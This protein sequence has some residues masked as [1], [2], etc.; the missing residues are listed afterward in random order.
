[1][2]IIYDGVRVEDVVAVTPNSTNPWEY[3]TSNYEDRYYVIKDT[4]HNSVSFTWKNVSVYYELG[5]NL[6]DY[7]IDTVVPGNDGNYYQI[8][9]LQYDGGASTF[10]SIREATMPVDVVEA[11]GAVVYD[12]AE[13]VVNGNFDIDTYGWDGGGTGID[14]LAEHSSRTGVGFLDGKTLNVG[15]W[16]RQVNIPVEIGVTYTFSCWWAGGSTGRNTRPIVID[17]NN[18]HLTTLLNVENTAVVPWTYYEEDFV[19]TT[20][21]TVEISLDNAGGFGYF[22]TI[23]IKKKV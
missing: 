21:D 13:L 19:S 3:E 14:W 16:V 5:I 8:G 9:T 22:D 15:K 18:D 23:S 6:D 7:P 17:A 12:K 10:Y 2:S 20:T 11:D 1:M 4:S